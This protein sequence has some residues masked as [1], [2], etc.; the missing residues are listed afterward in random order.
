LL[1]VMKNSYPKGRALM[2]IYRV[3]PVTKRGNSKKGGA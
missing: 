1:T 2:Q 3:D